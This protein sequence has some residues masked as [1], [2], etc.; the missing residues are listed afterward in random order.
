G[1]IYIHDESFDLIN[2][3]VRKKSNFTE[4]DNRLQYVAFDIIE[5][6]VIL[7]DR[8]EKL[9][10]IH[11]V[12]ISITSQP[13]DFL[14]IAMPKQINT[15][16]SLDLYFKEAIKAKFEGAIYRNA[17]SKYEFKRS[18][19]LLKRKRFFEITGILSGM[20]EGEKRLA[21]TL[22]AIEVKLPSG[23]MVRVGTGFS[24]NDRYHI[25]E[26]FG[27]DFK[28]GKKVTI[29]YQELTKAG[30][31]RFPVFIRWEN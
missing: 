28:K 2:G 29:K 26:D 25:W 23:A 24:D 11:A 30:V 27:G 10:W 12:S 8:I 14:I 15:Q 31:P 16:V 17:N 3:A 13:T 21:G 20:V 6:D 5:Q 7:R 19:N 9:N 1:E 18:F 4:M 22:G